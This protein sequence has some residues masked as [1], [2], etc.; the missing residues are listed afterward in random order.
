MAIAS[1][2]ADSEVTYKNVNTECTSDLK[3]IQKQNC[4]IKK[5]NDGF[6]SSHLNINF[7]KKW[8]L[9]CCLFSF[10]FQ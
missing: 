8:V 5:S 6:S 7:E 4:K 9:R 2:F 3:T 10:Y 1:Y